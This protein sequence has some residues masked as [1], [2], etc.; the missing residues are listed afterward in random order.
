MLKG[1]FDL[2]HRQ[3]ALARYIGTFLTQNTKKKSNDE[4]LP[5][6]RIAP[7]SQKLFTQMELA[8]VFLAHFMAT[9]RQF[10]RS[11]SGLCHATGSVLN[12]D[13][14]Q[15]LILSEICSPDA[16]LRLT[17]YW[18]LV[19]CDAFVQCSG[20]CAVCETRHATQVNPDGNK[21]KKKKKKKKKYYN[22]TR[23]A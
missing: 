22:T 3:P 16:K 9:F 17:G 8:T 21:K 12:A 10:P 14:H 23:T 6:Y 18:D 7:K 11:S 1:H 19:G 20:L 13:Q 4:Q 5:R 15:N 2:H